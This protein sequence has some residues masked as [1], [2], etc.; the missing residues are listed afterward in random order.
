MV[1]KTKVKGKTSKGIEYLI[2]RGKKKRETIVAR[3]VQDAV[4][5][6]HRM[7]PNVKVLGVERKKSRAGREYETYWI[8]H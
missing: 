7:Y 2:K 6:A 5:K 8:E 1:I 3:N 4:N